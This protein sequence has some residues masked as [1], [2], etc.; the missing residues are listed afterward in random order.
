[1]FSKI[2][3]SAAALAALAEATTYMGVEA[4]DAG[5][6]EEDLGNTFKLDGFH[7]P[8]EVKNCDLM[9]DLRN[10]DELQ[11][12]KQEGGLKLK[13]GETCKFILNENPSTGY[14][15][16]LNEAL[17]SDLYEVKD[18]YK[19]KPALPGMVGVGGAKEITITALKPGNGKLQAAKAR[20]WEF[21]GWDQAEDSSLVEALNIDIMVED[22]EDVIADEPKLSGSYDDLKLDFFEQNDD[23]IM[24]GGTMKMNQ[25]H[26]TLLDGLDSVF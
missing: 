16:L 3:I 18:S 13:V 14:S 17:P 12:F 23:P 10:Y 1:M 20:P 22:V 19:S 8:A 21:A 6:Y 26:D 25:A 9:L 24:L 2:T 4:I 5:N 7:D 15:W 11:K